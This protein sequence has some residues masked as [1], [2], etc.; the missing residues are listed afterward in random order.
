MKVS[1]VLIKPIVSEKSNKL[2]EKKRTYAFRVHRRANKLEIKKAVEELPRQQ[3]NVYRL[4]R[5]SGYKTAEIARTMGLSEQS[6]KNTLVR[7]LK[8][9]REYLEKAGHTLLLLFLIMDRY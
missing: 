6:V 1:E 2:S 4:R 7:A 9:I 8:F 5:E 3:K